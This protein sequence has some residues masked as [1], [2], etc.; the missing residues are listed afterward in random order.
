[1]N[2]EKL[3]EEKGGI[4]LDIG[5]GENK[6]GA[7]WVGMDIRELPGVEIVWDFEEFPWP[8]PDECVVRAIASHVVE[9]INPHKFGFINWMNEAW[10][11]MKPNGQLALALPYW[12]SPG[13]AQDPTHCNPCNEHTWAYFDPE[14]GGGVLYNIYKPKPWKL[15]YISWNPVANMEVI[16]RKRDEQK[17]D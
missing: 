17:E 5:C 1:M 16:M 10:R 6:Q 9:H 8:L 13:F 2:I 7:E 4:S 11:V 14:V 12:L 3:I 15:E